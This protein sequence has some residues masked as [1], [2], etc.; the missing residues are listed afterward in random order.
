VCSY[1]DCN[2]ENYESN[3]T[4]IFHC[5]KN[6]WFTLVRGDWVKKKVEEFWK[7]IRQQKHIINSQFI[8]FIFPAFEKYSCQFN[9]SSNIHQTGDYN[10]IDNTNFGLRSNHYNYYSYLPQAASFKMKPSS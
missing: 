5:K 7:E 10:C 1:E 6:D 2:F 4:C 8:G 9:L 3:D